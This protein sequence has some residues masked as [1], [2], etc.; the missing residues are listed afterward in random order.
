[1]TNGPIALAA[2]MPAADENARNNVRSRLRRLLCDDE[3][4]VSAVMASGLSSYLATVPENR[5][6]EILLG[7]FTAQST[8][9]QR[10]S[11]MLK[12][13][14]LELQLKA[15]KETQAEREGVTE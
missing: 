9:M 1:M 7:F 4:A 2:A 13:E 3:A 6:T 14:L 12:K 8:E 5:W 10:Q 15:L 11:L